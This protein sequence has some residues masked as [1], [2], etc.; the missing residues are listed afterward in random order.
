MQEYAKSE[1]Q[2]IYSTTYG[3]NVKMSISSTNS[4]RRSSS[5]WDTCSQHY[6]QWASYVWISDSIATT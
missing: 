3:T 1:W 5:E 4:N 6:T 2:V